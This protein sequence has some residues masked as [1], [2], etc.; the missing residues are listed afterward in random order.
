MLFR[1]GQLCSFAKRKTEEKV[2][3]ERGGGIKEES[4]PKLYETSLRELARSA[5]ER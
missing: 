2:E 1:F 4:A 3:G 5:K